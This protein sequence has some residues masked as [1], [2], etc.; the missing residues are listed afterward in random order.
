MR[1]CHVSFTCRSRAPSSRHVGRRHRSVLRQSEEDIRYNKCVIVYR[2]TG[3]QVLSEFPMGTKEIPNR[4]CLMRDRPRAVALL[5]MTS[6]RSTATV[7]RQTSDFPSFYTQSS[8]PR[9]ERWLPPLS[10]PPPL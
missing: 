1:V 10:I 9:L 7:A 2:N 4:V 6:A 8:P 5:L 3:L